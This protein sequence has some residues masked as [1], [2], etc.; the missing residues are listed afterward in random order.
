M[1]AARR[2]VKKKRLVRVRRVGPA[3]VVDRLFGHRGGQVP[4][5]LGLAP[6][7]E[8]RRVVAEQIRGPLVG[9]AD[10]KAV[11]ILEAIARRPLVERTDLG[12]VPC[13]RVVVLPEPGRRVAILDQDSPDRRP[14]LRDGG[15]VAREPR[16][17]LGDHAEAH[18]VVVPPADRGGASRRAQ[19]GVVHL[20]VAQSVGGELV[21]RGARDD[22]TESA[23]GSET[24]IVDLNQQHVGRALGRHH[25]RRPP[26]LGTL[27]GFLDDAFEFRCR[28][29][30][31]LAVDRGRAA[32]RAGRAG[33]LDLRTGTSR[34]G[35]AQGRSQSRN[36]DVAC[37]SHGCL[38]GGCSADRGN[39]Q[40]DL[41]REHRFLRGMPSI[42][43]SSLQIVRQTN[44]AD[45]D[46]NRSS[47]RS[48]AGSR[49]PV[50]GEAGGADLA[51]PRI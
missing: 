24:G 15:V 47:F 43:D 46:L 16:R 40:V 6:P 48:V 19:R 28:G 27:G 26:S 11:E 9:L 35:Q 8:D 17:S 10:R 31:L 2:V 20:R 18:R 25:A 4:G 21:Q 29:R 42:L 3:Q 32:G 49:D 39:S 36:S 12:R 1:R 44:P 30:E 33:G 51:S 45:V 37:G 50:E 7:R 34:K 23:R 13:R 22:S 14:V 38:L 41:C 5:A